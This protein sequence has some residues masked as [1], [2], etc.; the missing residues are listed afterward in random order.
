LQK[1]TK[2]AIRVLIA[3]MVEE[4]AAIMVEEAAAIM[5]EEAAAIMVE[6]EEQQLRRKVAA[7]VMGEVAV[8]VMPVI[9]HLPR[10]Q[11]T[12]K[13]VLIDQRLMLMVIVRH[14]LQTI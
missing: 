14:K 2:A 6:A 1:K 10:L 13:P 7:I 3:I 9:L 8:V 5:V 11:Q 12:K 4:A